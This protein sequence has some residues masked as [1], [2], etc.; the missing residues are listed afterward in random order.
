MKTLVVA[1]VAL[2]ATPA[3]ATVRFG[4]GH[5]DPFVFDHLLGDRYRRTHAARSIHVQKEMTC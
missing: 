5:S 4:S 2:Q 1:L 3:L